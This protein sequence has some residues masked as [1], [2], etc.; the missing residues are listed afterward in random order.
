MVHEQ[1]DLRKRRAPE[2]ETG[3]R[4]RMELIRP[5]LLTSLTETSSLP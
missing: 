1:D 4:E 2:R 3:E 5:Q